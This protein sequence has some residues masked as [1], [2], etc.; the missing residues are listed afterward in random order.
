MRKTL[1]DGRFHR[2]MS[3]YFAKI[4]LNKKKSKQ[5]AV[6][7][8]K[9]WRHAAV[10][11][12]VCAVALGC[13]LSP[14]NLIKYIKENRHTMGFSQALKNEMLVICNSYRQ[15][16]YYHV[17][18]AQPSIEDDEMEYDDDEGFTAVKPVA[19]DRAPKSA[20]KSPQPESGHEDMDDTTSDDTGLATALPEN[21]TPYDFG[22]YKVTPATALSITPEPTPSRF[23]ITGCFNCKSA[24]HADGMP[25]L[26]C[27]A[28]KKAI[29]CNLLW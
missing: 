8:R 5:G 23:T 22:A 27:G 17:P 11:L 16:E 15:G 2:V 14:P 21:R 18:S 24:G 28:C 13:E 4:G 3:E 1:D 20:S 26:V 9:P 29:Y 10:L 6:D 7:G 19:L 12:G 25:L